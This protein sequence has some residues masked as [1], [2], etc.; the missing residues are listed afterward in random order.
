MEK[1][2]HEFGVKQ[3]SF[4]KTLQN[5]PFHSI[6]LKFFLFG[7]KKLEMLFLYFFDPEVEIQLLL[8]PY[9]MCS[10]IK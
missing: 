5:V 10:I 2:F 9:L 4:A 7:H 8:V 6:S 3:F 1:G